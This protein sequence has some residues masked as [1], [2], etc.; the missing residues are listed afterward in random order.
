MIVIPAIDLLNG[1][2]A[3]LKRG[4]FSFEKIYSEDPVSVAKKWENLGAKRIHIVDLDGA[5]SGV[6]RNLSLIENILKNIDIPAELGGGV[7]SE[8]V[9]EEAFSKGV[10]YIII[11][12]RALDDDF[13]KKMVKK[14]R[15]KIIVGVDIKDG[16]VSISGWAQTT[17][18]DYIE[19]IK[20][21]EGLGV[22]SI[23][24]TDIAKDG[25]LSGP[26]IMAI[27]Q[28]LSHTNINVIASGGISNISDLIK[29]KKLPCREPFGVI[30][31]KALY[32]GKIDLKEAIKAIS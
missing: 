8:A 27:Q 21:L 31:G 15:D 22:S 32:E 28:V 11:G 25:M 2:V 10:S 26:N 20:R 7:R 9:V 12:T 19:F 16:K 14:Y 5:R 17:T 4:D 18:L 24:F 3:R 30:V 29:L 6:F 23:V 13:I 1:R